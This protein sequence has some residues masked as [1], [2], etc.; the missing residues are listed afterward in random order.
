MKG[1]LSMLVILVVLGAGSVFAKSKSEKFEVKGNCESCESR[2]EKAALSVE[3]VS[4][5]DWNKD[6]KM[7]ELA[8]EDSKTDL[9]KVETAIARAGYDTPMQKAS[10]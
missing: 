4:K 9:K 2:I 5:A 6:T 10:D 1:K 8:F 7:M 3:G